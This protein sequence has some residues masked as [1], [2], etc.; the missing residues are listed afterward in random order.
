MNV[1]VFGA[2]YVGLPT[3]ALFATQH[4][5]TII[6]SDRSKVDLIRE[7]ICPFIDSELQA[8]MS[9]HSQLLSA[10]YD[11]Y[12]YL[13]IQLAIIATPTPT[14]SSGEQDDSTI[15]SCLNTINK[16]LIIALL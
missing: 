13:R 15:E 11:N 16:Y 3:A 1:V 5:V 9:S 4:Q 6:D 10:Q 12:P 2:G 8:W 7:G 14:L